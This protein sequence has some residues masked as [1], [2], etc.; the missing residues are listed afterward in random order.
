M[1]STK[2]FRSLLKI[3]HRWLDRLIIIAIA[4]ITCFYIYG[5]KIEPNWLEVVSIPV[6]IPH[7]TPAFNN[8]KLV[9]I[10]DI[11]LGR[12]M[13]EKRLDRII[14]LV[15]EQNPDAIAIT[16]DIITKHHSL[17]K[18]EIFNKLNQ[19][20]SQE[21]N[22]AVLGNHDHWRNK[23]KTDVLKKALANNHILNLENQVYILHRG[24]EKLTFAGLDDPYVG[25]PDFK[26][27]IRQLPNDGATILLVHEPDFIDR[28]AK[29]NLFDLQLSGHSH[30]GQI[31]FPFFEP[32]ILP[33]G[34]QKYFAGLHQVNNTLE[35]TNRGLGMT[36]VPLRFNSRPEITVFTLKTEQ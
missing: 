10:S 2:Y 11:H 13:P 36:G 32:I 34:G 20:I 3:S 6:A 21:C 30:G 17:V 9:Q 1:A 33:Y 25:N 5:A 18:P 27:V 35:Y 23:E 4:L 7:L 24:K 26:R 15:N 29:T 19:L 31:K 12:F 14:K 28:S 16:G 8:F 22:V